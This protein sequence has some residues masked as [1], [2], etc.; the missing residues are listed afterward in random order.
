MI[1][2]DRVYIIDILF[3]MF[4]LFFLFGGLRHGLSG[5]LARILALFVLL[6]TTL[7][8]YPQW[9][10]FAARHLPELSQWMLQLGVILA[11]VM[12]SLLLFILLQMLFK[13]L[14]KSRIGEV[15]D[16]LVGSLVGLIRGTLIG[17]TLMVGLSLLPSPTLYQ[18]LFM[19]STIGRWVCTTLTPWIYPRML[20]LPVFDQ[21]EA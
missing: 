9:M 18:T 5:E 15:T 10:Q 17:L 4:V 11:L 2:P 3:A 13:Q 12:A 7:F 6:L 8:F 16:K 1:F 20:E 19:K 21:E 14:F